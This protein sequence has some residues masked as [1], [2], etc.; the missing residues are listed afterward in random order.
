MVGGH[1]QAESDKAEIG[2]FLF[3]VPTLGD[4]GAI[5]GGVDV[6]G[7]VRHVQHQPGQIHI[8]H[9]HHPRGDACF[10]LDEMGGGDG[11]HCVPEP[12]MIQRCC[13]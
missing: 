12:A 3:R 5:I 8:E 13:W 7:E 10:D 2:A 1:D 9:L 11:V 6:G 4:R